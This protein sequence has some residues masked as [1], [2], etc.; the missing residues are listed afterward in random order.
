MHRSVQTI[1]LAT[2][3]LMLTEGCPSP[4]PDEG[5][6]PIVGDWTATRVA[7]EDFPYH[8]EYTYSGYYN[9]F[10]IT[11]D[12][13]AELSIYADM[14]GYFDQFG[15]VVYTFDDRVSSYDFSNYLAVHVPEVEGGH[16]EIVMR[17]QEQVNK[18]TCTLNEPE[19]NCRDRLE[20]SWDFTRM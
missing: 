14:T 19:L 16:Y 9:E 11:V 1:P 2:L 13:E 18:L 20:R 7:D 10:T 12:I 17:D 4:T 15:Y 6:D 8:Y 5:A 3:G